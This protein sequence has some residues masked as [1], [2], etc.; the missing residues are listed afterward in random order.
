MLDV[1]RCA[2]EW[3]PASPCLLL[4][5]CVTIFIR[6]IYYQEEH[7]QKA[8]KAREDLRAFLESNKKMNSSVRWRHASDIF[9]GVP[10]WEAVNE[11]DRKDVFDDVIFFLAKR[12]KEEEK[13]QRIKNRAL[14]LQVYNSMPG[15]T[16]RTLWSE[17]S[18]YICINIL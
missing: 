11:R 6:Y 8:K 14:M 12:E 1:E 3:F 15:I 16:Y 9:D 2:V 7:R 13:E 17:V 18:Y 10:E 5:K 4:Y